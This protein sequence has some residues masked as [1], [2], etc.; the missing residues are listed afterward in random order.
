MNERTYVV[1]MVMFYG[2]VPF[3]RIYLQKACV[4]VLYC[5]VCFWRESCFIRGSQSTRPG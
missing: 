1:V 5:V 3:L 2:C 4:Y